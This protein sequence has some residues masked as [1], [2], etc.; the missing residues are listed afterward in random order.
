MIQHIVLFKLKEFENEDQK[1]VVRNK[2]KK[3]LISLKEKIEVLR[4]IY[5]GQNFELITSSYDVCLISHFESLDDLDVYLV[6]TENLKVDELLKANTSGRAVI[7]F[8]F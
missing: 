3:A 5:V 6:H 7:D 1:A 2:I 4:Y 8:E